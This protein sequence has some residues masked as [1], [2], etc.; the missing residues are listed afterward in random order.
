LHRDTR[1][2][3]CP[4]TPGCRRRAWQASEKADSFIGC[5]R[6]RRARASRA[7]PAPEC[8]LAA[9][10]GG[11]RRMSGRTPCDGFAVAS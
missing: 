9:H 10:R 3:Q 7:A 4:F 5:E 1:D 8:D 2:P 6:N 11:E